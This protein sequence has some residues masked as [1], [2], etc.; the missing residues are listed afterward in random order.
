MEAPGELRLSLAGD[1][2]RAEVDAEHRPGDLS[3]RDATVATGSRCVLLSGEA[4]ECTMAIWMWMVKLWIMTSA[5]WCMIAR[6]GP[7]PRPPSG[8]R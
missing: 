6:A 3:A 4:A 8:G 7:M 1:C 5:A 2:D